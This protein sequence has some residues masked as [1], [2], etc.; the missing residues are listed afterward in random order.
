M[1]RLQPLTRFVFLS[2]LVAGPALAQLPPVPTPPENPTT[3]N[4]VL[5]GKILF[6]EEQMSSDD[7]TACGTCH[8]PS[9][10]GGD[11][12]T[13]T[14]QNLHPGPDQAFLTADDIRGSRG[15][16]RCNPNGAFVSEP[17]FFPNSQVTG[18]KSP[19]FIGVAWAPELFWEGRA[20]ATFKDPVTQAV[21]IPNFAALESQAVGPIVSDV[22]MACRLRTHLQVAGKIASVT[23]LRLATN[24]PPDVSAHL[25]VYPTYPQLFAAAFG[26]S[27]VTPARIGMAIA[28]YERTLI[29]DQ[30]PWDAFQAG[31]ASALTA[32]QQAG[33]TLFLGAANCATCHIPPLFTDHSFANI[34][35]RPDTDDVGRFSV[36]NTPGDEGKFRVPSL[37]NAGLRAPFFHNGGAPDMFSVMLFYQVGGDFPGP[38]LDPRLMPLTLTHTQRLQVM[39]FVENGL[40]DPRVAAQA[41]PFDRP[42][43]NSEVVANFPAQYGT[44]T[45]G[46]G[47]IGPVIVAPHSAFLGNHAFVFGLAKGLGMAP[48]ALAITAAQAAPGAM[49]GLNPLWVDLNQLVSYNPVVLAGAPATPGTGYTSF[50]VDI[51]YLP[52]IANVTAYV[53]GATFDAAGPGGLA[54]TGGAQITIK[55]LGP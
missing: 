39:D 29:P 10:G 13:N 18:R 49:I 19:S 47:G 55:D 7:T 42:T 24:L 36:T 22:E 33:L 28:A 34:G 25:A 8:I 6:W 37:R 54:V 53:Q 15:V 35:V 4:K 45:A 27:A 5:L 11:P 44:G 3:P 43:L 38:N 31:N 50:L 52:A 48:A 46:T 2:V 14:P 9:V 1:S 16:V 40:L 23:P 32:D 12:R 17:N 21:L 30:T 20:S 26:D 41:F 51:P